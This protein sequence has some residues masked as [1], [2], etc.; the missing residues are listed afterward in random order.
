MLLELVETMLMGVT[1]DVERVAVVVC[2]LAGRR[3]RLDLY[4]WSASGSVL[5]FLNLA[6]G[7]P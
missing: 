7:N 2:G 6:P 3:G 4:H 5:N 1:V